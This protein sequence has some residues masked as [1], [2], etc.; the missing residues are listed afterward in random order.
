MKIEIDI[1]KLVSRSIIDGILNPNNIQKEVNDIL[2]GDDCQK[3]LNVHIKTRLSEILLSED[4]AK[5][6]DKSII[7][8]I[9]NSCA[10]S[11]KI[12]SDIEEI[13]ENDEYQKILTQRIKDCF[14]EVIFS[15]EGKKQISCKVQE[16][17]ENYDI[18]CND[19]FSDELNKGIADIL[20]MVI[21][22]SFERL[23]TS[24]MRTI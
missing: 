8:G 6:I 12:E 21:K 1:E 7:D 11:D 10:N 24:N 18:E 16:Y 14:R 19:S 20:L 5:Q 9:T 17:L 2:K 22:D 23:K 4:G 15:E 3:I 13:L